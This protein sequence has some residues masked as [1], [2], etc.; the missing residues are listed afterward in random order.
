MLYSNDINFLYVISIFEGG[1][2]A[3]LTTDTKTIKRKT[4]RHNTYAASIS[5]HGL[6]QHLAA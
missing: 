6:R 5:I 3:I 2:Y 1:H 4:K